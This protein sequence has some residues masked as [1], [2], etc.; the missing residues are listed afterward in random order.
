MLGAW[1]ERSLDAIAASDIETLR[2]QVAA[3]ARSRRTS[4]GG[5]HAGEHVIAAAR[6]VYTRAIADGLLDAGASPAHRVAKPRRLPSTRRALHPDELAA[7]D[8]VARTSGN[9]VILDALLLRVHTETACRRGGALGLRLADLDP[10]RGLVRLTEK[11][12]TVRWQP[13]T[14]DL[15]THLQEHARTRGRGAA[16]RPAAALPQRAADHQPPLRPPLGPYRR[17]ATLGRRPGRLHPLATPH[18]ADLGRAA[19]RLR[20]RPRLRQTHRLHRPGHHHLH[21]HS[22]TPM[23]R[24]SRL[25]VIV[26]EVGRVVVQE[27]TGLVAGLSGPWSDGSSCSQRRGPGS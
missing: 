12:G 22:V 15:V 26:A 19:L 1:D 8:L 24:A 14:L 5:R 9:D 20:H 11:G 27:A 25:V 2:R 23:N 13:I 4:R 18:H 17:A 16:H 21:H 10:D 6:A 7:I 3:T